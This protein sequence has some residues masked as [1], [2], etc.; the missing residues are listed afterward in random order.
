MQREMDVA[1]AEQEW[2]R[3]A[4]MVPEQA[5]LFY[6]KGRGPREVKALQVD[7]PSDA[8]LGS[9][10]NGGPVGV[11]GSE[12]I[13]ERTKIASFQEAAETRPLGR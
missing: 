12:A 4:R 2:E 8:Q 10:S 3:R 11:N 7:P 1:A 5:G 13:Q 9:P 6:G